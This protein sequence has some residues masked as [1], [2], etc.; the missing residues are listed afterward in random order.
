[1]CNGGNGPRIQTVGY[2]FVQEIPLLVNERGTD[3][4]TFVRLGARSLDMTRYPATI[5]SLVRTVKFI[6]D[7]DMTAGATSA[8]VKLYNLTN[9]EDITGTS[10]THNTVV[11]TEKTSAALTVGVAAGNIRSGA[12]QYV[13]YLKMNGGVVAVDQAFCTNARIEIAYA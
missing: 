11:N 3:S 8:E 13:A 1:M 5:G 2:I 9:A 10:L 12:A 4:A 7:L 6:A